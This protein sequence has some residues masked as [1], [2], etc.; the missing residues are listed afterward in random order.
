MCIHTNIEAY[1]HVSERSS[2]FGLLAL[3]SAF[4]LLS[5]ITGQTDRT[6][7]KPT[8]R[9]IFITA[10]S[11]SRARRRIRP[12][13]RNAESEQLL[14]EPEPEPEPEPEASRPR[15]PANSRRVQGPAT[16][17]QTGDILAATPASSRCTSRAT[18]PR[19]TARQ[20]VPKSEECWPVTRLIEKYP[21]LRYERWLPGNLRSVKKTGSLGS[22]DRLLRG[23]RGNPLC[24]WC[25]KE[26]Q[27]RNKLFCAAPRGSWSRRLTTGFGEGCE[28]EHRLRRDNQYV[29]AQMNIRDR[30]L[31][32]DCGIDTHHLFRR[33][34]GCTTLDQRIAM[35]KELSAISPEWLKKVKRPLSSMDYTFNEGMFWE[36]AHVIDVKHGGGLCG[37]E[38]YHTLCVPCHNE[39]YMRNYMTDLSTLPLYQSPSGV[40]KNT[41]RT[42]TRAG[43]STRTPNHAP[44]TSVPAPT[45]SARR[46]RAAA[47][48]AATASASTSA[49]VSAAME[50]HAPP[51]AAP[52]TSPSTTPR[53][54]QTS[55]RSAARYAAPLSTRQPPGSVQFS[56]VRSP[57]KS[58]PS[59]SSSDSL[60][61]PMSSF[62][63]YAQHTR[64]DETPTR[65]PGNSLAVIDLTAPRH[66]P[67]ATRRN[68]SA[69]ASAKAALAAIDISSSEESE[70]DLFQSIRLPGS[71]FR[72]H[73]RLFSKSPGSAAVT[74]SKRPTSK[75]TQEHST[76]TSNRSSTKIA[77]PSTA[78]TASAIAGRPMHMARRGHGRDPVLPAGL[79]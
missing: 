71:H 9:L 44:A 47:A 4:S 79:H 38:G 70:E 3:R 74:E 11:R 49:S 72:Q 22:D 56:M 12:R 28:H 50:A 30:G 10:R 69:A 20:V 48:A 77:A 66:S 33:A 14:S 42:P 63:L 46:T 53:V 65:R 27:G 62:S 26:T 51:A 76:T 21:D 40:P 52:V 67:L 2:P 36:A 39:E 18:A 8:P 31:C 57:P 17:A 41:P 75:R 29:R 59:F 68:P 24:L 35:F 15:T 34:V 7:A 32:F 54:V 78:A 16:P 13:A 45:S 64:Q 25:G 19:S 55:L 43:I 60:P 6:T 5:S 58:M 37:L 1:Q 73:A 23:S 61:S